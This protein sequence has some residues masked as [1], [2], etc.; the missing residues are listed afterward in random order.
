VS[1]AAGGADRESV[2]DIKFSAAAQFSTQ[3]R[4]V[5]FKDY[6]SYILNNY[7][8]LD[9]VSI[10]GGEDNV[11]RVYGKVFVSLKPT[12]NYYISEAEKERIIDEIISPKAI[13]AVQTEI[14]DPEFLYLI[15]ESDVQYDAK[16]TNSSE[17][18]IK[19]SIRNAVLTYRDRELNKFDTRFILSKMQDDIDDTDLNAILGSETIVRVQ[20]RFKPAIGVSQ[21]Y[22]INFN[23]PLH[24]GTISNKL[25]SS[26]FGVNDS[27]GVRRN[28]TFEEIP[29]SFSGITSIS[30]TNPGVGYTTAPTVTITGDGTGAT[31]TATIVNG[32]IQ[33]I[34]VSNRGIDYSRAIITITG[35]GGYG[36]TATA[37][38]DA[39]TG[40]LRTIYYDTNAERQIVDSTA[41]TI[42]YDTGVITIDDINIRSIDTD[43]ELIR[44]SIESEKGIIQSVRNTILT[45]DEEDPTSIVTTLEAI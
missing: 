30:I 17:T 8:N 29:Q 3:N 45:I 19:Q 28:V 7:P 9:S 12:A 40:V 20:K 41:G 24:R 34:D 21:A 43:D 4:L 18:A 37:V 32:S 31:A 36:A 16:K 2:D 35:G 38:I 44:L 6:E 5:T 1:A 25:V 23:V 22:T 42:D 26:E 11:P 10:W 15:V 33:S 14:L 39:R 13:V 27:N